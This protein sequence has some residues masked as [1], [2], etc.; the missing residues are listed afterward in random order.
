MS[1]GRF[2]IFVALGIGGLLMAQKAAASINPDPYA[3]D[4]SDLRRGERLNNPGN[5]RHSSDQWQG[6][7]PDQP[8]PYFVNF[9]APEWGFRAMAKNLLTYYDAY[10]L[11]TVASIISRW[12]PS[13]EN[14]T[15]AYIGRV[16]QSMGIAPTMTLD[17]HDAGVLAA[18]MRA[19]V[20]VEQ[21]RVIWGPEILAQGIAA[22]GVA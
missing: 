19:M 13:N 11:D 14:Q 21:G 4:G 20:Q 22:A 9:I 12:A 2:I 16:A 1:N 10:G 8:D 17:L 15:G 18:L 5:I 7:S 6:M 3:A